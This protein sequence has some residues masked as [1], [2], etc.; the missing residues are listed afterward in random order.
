MGSKWMKLLHPTPFG[1]MGEKPIPLFMGIG[2]SFYLTMSIVSFTSPFLQIGM[3]TTW[4]TPCALILIGS[5]LH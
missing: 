2:F 4:I 5:I 1:I 3:T